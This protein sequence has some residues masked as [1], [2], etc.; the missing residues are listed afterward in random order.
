MITGIIIGLLVGTPFGVIIGALC[1]MSKRTSE[2]EER[3]EFH[4]FW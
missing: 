1:F 2:Q 3:T 4:K